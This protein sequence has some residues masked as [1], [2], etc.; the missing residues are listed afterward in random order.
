M[1]DDV[2][3]EMKL[4]TQGNRRKT[5]RILKKK[6]NELGGIKREIVLLVSESTFLPTLEYFYV[7]SDESDKRCEGYGWNERICM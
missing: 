6:K 2:V 4:R 5:K 3:G 7:H 1:C